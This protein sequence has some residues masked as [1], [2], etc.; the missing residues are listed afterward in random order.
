MYSLNPVY[1]DDVDMRWDVNRK[2]VCQ[3]LT[4]PEDIGHHACALVD[5]LGGRWFPIINAQ[6]IFNR[7]TKIHSKMDIFQANCPFLQGLSSVSSS[8]ELQ[9]WLYCF[10]VP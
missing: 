1:F 6:M 8:L 2:P 3:P 7:K 4:H 10:N 5:G 9:L